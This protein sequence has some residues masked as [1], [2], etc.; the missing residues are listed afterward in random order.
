MA[1]AP[2][3]GGA[4]APLPGGNGDQPVDNAAISAEMK[5]MQAEA[6]EMQLLQMEHSNEMEKISGL[7]Q[8][9]KG[10]DDKKNQIINNFK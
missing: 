9:I 5:K 8:T 2:A 7:A 1:V 4:P 10:G 6:K 3:G